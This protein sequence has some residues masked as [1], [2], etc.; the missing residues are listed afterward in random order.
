MAAGGTSELVGD[1]GRRAARLLATGDAPAWPNGAAFERAGTL[2]SPG[3]GP[4]RWPSRREAMPWVH[5]WSDPF[6]GRENRSVPAVDP[7]APPPMHP[8]VEVL[9]ALLGTWS[10]RGHGEYPTIEPFDYEETV[11]I[12]QVGKPFL[13]YVQRTVDAVTGRPLHAETGYFRLAGPGWVELVVSHPTGIVEVDE[14][15]FDGTA[16]RLRSRAMARTGSAKEVTAIERD[17]DV[18]GDRLGYSLRMAAVG[19]PLTHHLAA[20]LRRTGA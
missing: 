1:D 15:T 3:E 10:G 19:Q 9:R 18:D 12:T 14:G 20:D 17:V 6:R 11:T 8:D 2:M 4:G 13:A 5:I 7:T 16:L